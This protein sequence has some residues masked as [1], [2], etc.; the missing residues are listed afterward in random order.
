MEFKN[1][2]FNAAKDGKLKRLKVF[3]DHRPKEEVEMLVSATTNGATPLVMAS[4]NGHLEVADYLLEKCHADIEQVGSVT[5]EGETIEG[6]PPLWCAA[7][8]GHLGVVQGLVSRGA[9][10]NATTRTNSTPL[11]AACF[12][13][14]LDIV[15]FLVE[16]GA[17][18]EIAN[19]HGHT[20]LMIACYKGHLDIAAYLVSRGAHVDRKS[21]KGNTALHD[22]AESGSLEILRLLLE[23]GA[24]AERDAYGLTPLLAAAVTGHASV[25]EFL[26]ALPDCPRDQRVEALELLG[27]TYVDKRRDSPRAL[28]LWRRALAERCTEPPLPKPRRAPAAAY[29]DAVEASS[30]ADLEDLLCE[31]D[32]MRMQALLV[33]ERVLGPAHPDTAYY[34]R[35]RGAVYADLGDFPRCVHLWLYALD[36][37][38]RCLEPFSPMTQSSLLSFAELFSFM[39]AEARPSRPSRRHLAPVEFADVL[40]VFERA[41]LELL[42]A[43]PQSPRP[44][45]PQPPE[46]VHRTLVIALQLAALLCRLEPQDDEGERFRRAAYRLVR[47]DVRGANGDTCLHVACRRESTCLGRQTPAL[48]T[49]CADSFPAPELVRLLLD[50]GADPNAT[51]DDLSTP[52]HVA[53]RSRPCAR[54]AA[55]ALLARGAHLDRADRFGRTALDYA[56]ALVEGSPLRFAGLRCLC[57]RAIVRQGVPF[58]GLVPRELESFVQCH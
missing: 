21:A 1:A 34:I 27:A 23:H 55:A 10:V 26:A 43:G 57:A 53:A 56:P 31:P 15:R 12:D 51:D 22:C 14:H 8:A 47:L 44:L 20:C 50:V 9:R 5:F 4:R 49:V 25:V 48:G 13:G 24:K 18:L 58:R 35:Y 45:Q 17:D 16:Q 30:L 29:G 37:Q 11:R 7:A 41:V 46:G 54:A 28:S 3:L 33:R 32:H 2:V 42:S 38:Q 19:R 39:M 6:A 40:A 52:L 36:M